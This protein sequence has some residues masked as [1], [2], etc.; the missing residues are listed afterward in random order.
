MVSLDDI[1]IRSV[2]LD[3]SKRPREAI[4]KEISDV[5]AIT[6]KY[7]SE[8]YSIYVYRFFINNWPDLT[9]VAMHQDRMVGNIICKVEPHR[10]VRIR[11]YIGMLSVE[12]EYRGLG[13]AKKLIED[14]INLM[15]EKY[16]CDEITLET[17]VINKKALRLYEDYGFIR[18]KRLYRYYMNRHDA[19]RLVLPITERS[20]VCSSQLLP[21]E[22]LVETKY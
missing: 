9:L 8:P 11:G 15:I 13:I 16:K 18:I 21:L 19:Y 5:E 2:C 10:N 14:A 20:T 3:A 17:E 4:D 6:N 22:N 12:H 7:L 1:D